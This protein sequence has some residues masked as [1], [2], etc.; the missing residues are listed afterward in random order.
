M[1]NAFDGAAAE[2]TFIEEMK[3]CSAFFN[4]ADARQT[5]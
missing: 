4:M 2:H 1:C 3:V 5:V